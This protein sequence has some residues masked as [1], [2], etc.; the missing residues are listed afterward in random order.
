MTQVDISAAARRDLARQPLTALGLWGLPLVLA[1]TTNWLTL[2]TAGV[3]SVWAAALTW[4]GIG[5]FINARRCHRLHCAIAAPV[6]LTGAGLA[7]AVAAG[8]FAAWPQAL[9]VVVNVTLVAVAISFAPEFFWGRYGR[10]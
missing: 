1:M 9:G 2:P 7:G 5:C 10:G 4:M 6:L 3:A 8:V